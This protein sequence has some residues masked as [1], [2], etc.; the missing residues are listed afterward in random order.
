MPFTSVKIAVFTPIPN[1]SE[2]IATATNPGLFARLRQAWRASCRSCSS[3]MKDRS[4]RCISR[5]CSTPPQERRAA[6]RAS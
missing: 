4:S 1:A 5:V 2:S 3:H 6:R